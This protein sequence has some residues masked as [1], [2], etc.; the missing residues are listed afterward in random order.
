MMDSIRFNDFV[1]SKV[2]T[3]PNNFNYSI[4]IGAINRFKDTN[5]N[6]PNTDLWLKNIDNN[7]FVFCDCKTGDKYNYIDTD[8][9]YNSYEKKHILAMYCSN[10]SKKE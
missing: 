6:Q 8:N 3:L 7:I 9:Q 4:G 1:N 10:K 2:Y 5:K